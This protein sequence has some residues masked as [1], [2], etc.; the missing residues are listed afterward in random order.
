MATSL[1]IYR[2]YVTLP[3]FTHGI[4]LA[5]LQELLTDGEI[6]LI[7][8]QLGHTW[9]DR[10]F[11]RAVTV[12]SMVHRALN[13]DKSIRATLTDLAVA[14]DRLEQ[15]PAGASWCQARSRLPEKLWAELLQSSVSR[16]KQLTSDQYV[17]KQ[18]PVYLIDGSTLS[19]PD[20]PDL[21]EQF[22]Y[23]YV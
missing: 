10:I 2:G 14:D 16:L 8:R 21:I 13:P 18:R 11:T 6:E 23:A 12:R 4:Q 3:Q 9:R 15:T 17:Y 7:C 20:T 19:M 1:A 22:G 5:A